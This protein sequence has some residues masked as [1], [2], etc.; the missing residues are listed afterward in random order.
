MEKINI[1]P[2]EFIEWLLRTSMGRQYVGKGLADA[3]YTLTKN[4]LVNSKNNSCLELF[5]IED[6]NDTDDPT[7]LITIYDMITILEFEF[8]LWTI[9]GPIPE[10][11]LKTSYQKHSSEQNGDDNYKKNEAFV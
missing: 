5:S 10:S 11:V 8:G 6:S 1:L 4:I 7:A 2:K 3:A 9:E